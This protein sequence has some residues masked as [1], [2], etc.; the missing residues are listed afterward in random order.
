MILPSVQYCG[1]G[2]DSPINVMIDNFIVD[3]DDNSNNQNDNDDN[4][5]FDRYIPS[6][7]NNNAN[8]DKDNINFNTQI[9]SSISS[10]S[11]SLIMKPLKLPLD[12]I[13]GKKFSNSNNNTIRTEADILIQCYIDQLD[14]NN[15]Y[16]DD[17]D[18]E[19]IEV[20]INENDNNDNDNEKNN[21]ND[22][23]NENDFIMP[24]RVYETLNNNISNSHNDDE[25][26]NI[27]IVEEFESSSQ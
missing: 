21:D 20:I 3:D 8:D 23:D 5:D 1:G 10:I 6:F 26:S 13:L 9:S 27:T 19:N 7:S 18:N 17:N 25:S 24:R 16:N 2:I 11:S 4:N 12:S 15:E 22:N 14:N